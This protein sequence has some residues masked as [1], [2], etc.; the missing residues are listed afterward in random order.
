MVAG[1]RLLD[2]R[3]ICK[4]HDKVIV[5]FLCRFYTEYIE[6]I[7]Y[8]IYYYIPPRAHFPILSFYRRTREKYFY[9]VHWA[10]K[11]IRRGRHSRPSVT[12]SKPR[13]HAE[14]SFQQFR[15]LLCPPVPRKCPGDTPD[16]AWG[17]RAW[18]I[19]Q[20]ILSVTGSFIKVTADSIITH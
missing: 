20:L 19:R 11:A 8:T 18:T 15:A 5:P 10:L 12:N 4:Q 3:G 2:N 13:M 9:K 6:Y 1:V 7:H 16:E 17:S 14:P